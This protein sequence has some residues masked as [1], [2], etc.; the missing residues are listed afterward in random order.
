MAYLRKTPPTIPQIWEFH[1]KS[2]PYR[3]DTN[4]SYLYS[5]GVL[6]LVDLFSLTTNFDDQERSFII[7]TNYAF[8][9]SFKN[10]SSDRFDYKVSQIKSILGSKFLL[11]PIRLKCETIIFSLTNAPPKKYL[12]RYVGKSGSSLQS[13]TLF[14][15][16]MNEA[17]G[18]QRVGVEIFRRILSGPPSNTEIYSNRYLYFSQ[19]RYQSF[20]EKALFVLDLEALAGVAIYGQAGSASTPLYLVSEVLKRIPVEIEPIVSNWV[21]AEGV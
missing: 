10:P 4:N 12:I 15:K 17:L 11:P 19:S 7:I 20:Q 8:A 3:F 6:F 2:K 5:T 18:S 14:A 13:D 9:P 21:K 16:S 1:E